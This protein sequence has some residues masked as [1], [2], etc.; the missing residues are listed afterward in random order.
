MIHVI[1]PGLKT[2]IQDMGRF[3]SYH[4]G[5][6]PS[7]AADKNSYLI[8]NILLGNP[9][10]YPVI[11]MMINGATFEFR[12][13]TVITVVGAPADVWLNGIA[14]PMWQTVTIQSGD[15]LQIKNIRKGVYTYLCISGGIAIAPLLNSYSTC[16]VSDFE[17]L[18]GKVMEAGDMIPLNEPLPGVLKQAGKK[19]PKSFY[20]TFSEELDVHVVMGITCDRISDEGLNGFLESEWKIH[21]NSNR[22]AYR[23]KGGRVEYSKQAPPFGSGNNPGN[24]V[25]IPYPVGAI[26]IPNEEEVIVLLNDGTGGGGFVTIGTVISSDISLLYQARPSSVVRFHASTVDQ[27]LQI[28]KEKEFQMQKLKAAV[29][30][31][32]AL[33]GQ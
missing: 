10:Y 7:G 33:Y 25:D 6:P 3:G 12:K 29:W 4:L 8:G 2:T 5:V 16:L 30:P 18:L 14:I 27:A 19:L 24:I 13:Q 1:E 26:I 31:D 22:D 20:P 15:I 28:R 17:G 23:L 9:K 11:E 21:Y 32:T